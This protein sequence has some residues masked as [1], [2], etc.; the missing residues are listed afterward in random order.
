MW[1]FDQFLQKSSF[2]QEGLFLVALPFRPC[3]PDVRV[4]EEGLKRPQSKLSSTSLPNAPYSH[5]K[6]FAG[7]FPH[8][9]VILKVS[10]EGKCQL[11]RWLAWWTWKREAG[12]PR[13]RRFAQKVSQGFLFGTHRSFC[14]VLE[15]GLQKSGALPRSR[16]QCWC[17][18]LWKTLK[19]KP[20]SE[21]ALHTHLRVNPLV[22][23]C[24]GFWSSRNC[25]AR[26]LHQWSLT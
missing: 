22:L 16:H 18:R 7:S 6:Y 4:A 5:C 25:G 15:T 14:H 2:V 19:S 17:H 10:S 9:L 12:R 20:L 13:T 3:H 23:A 26:Q 8:S 11:S 21:A 24:L 1:I